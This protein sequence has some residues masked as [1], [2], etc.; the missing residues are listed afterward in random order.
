MI[1]L[2]FKVANMSL[3][4]TF[5]DTVFNFTVV[6]TDDNNIYPFCSKISQGENK[7][8]KQELDLLKLSTDEN[9]SHPQDLTDELKILK[10]ELAKVWDILKIKVCNA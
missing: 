8:L 4:F 1:I 10:E 9:A 5:L 7:Q 2:Q 6:T 3:Y